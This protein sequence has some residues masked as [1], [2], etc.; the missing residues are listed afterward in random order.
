MRYLLTL[1]IFL[2]LATLAQVKAPYGFE[3]YRT[4]DCI[5]FCIQQFAQKNDS[6]VCRLDTILK[7]NTRTIYIMKAPYIEHLPDTASGYNIKVADVEADAAMLYKEQC[8]NGAVILYLSDGLAKHSYWTVWCMP[9]IA[10]KKS[11]KKYQVRFD[12]S[13]GFKNVFFFNDATAKFTYDRTECFN[14]N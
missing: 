9:M 7:P 2:P 5:R 13:R 10:E 6:L 12:D 1:L 4:Y 3:G 8:E 14:G 11:K